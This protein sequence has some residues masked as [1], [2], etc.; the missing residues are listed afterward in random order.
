VRAAARSELK[1][2]TA[3]SPSKWRYRLPR[4]FYTAIAVPKDSESMGRE[5]KPCSLSA[6]NNTA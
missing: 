4:L 1:V 5:D 2:A 6:A 3:H